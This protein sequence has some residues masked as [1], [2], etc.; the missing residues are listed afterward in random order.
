M[1]INLNNHFLQ[2]GRL[3][4][5]FCCETL[6]GVLPLDPTQ[7][8]PSLRP[9]LLLRI[10]I[11]SSY[12]IDENIAP[13]NTFTGSRGSLSLSA[14]I[15]ILL[16]HMHSTYAYACMLC[17]SG[18]GAGW[19]AQEIK[20]HVDTNRELFLRAV[21]HMECENGQQLDGISKSGVSVRIALV[22]NYTV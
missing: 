18:I 13:S 7:G 19:V 8:L 20:Q 10:E 15:I 9:F 1:C 17:S 2:S 12:T 4:G 22:F 14:C 11:F 6:T 16:M 3:L 5:G 21:T